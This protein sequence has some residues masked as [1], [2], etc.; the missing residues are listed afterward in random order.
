MVEI[1]R[2]ALAA[3]AVPFPVV[4]MSETAPPARVPME[5]GAVQPPTDAMPPPTMPAPIAVPLALASSVVLAAPLPPMDQRAICNICILEMSAGLDSAIREMMI[6][7]L[8]ES[9]L[10]H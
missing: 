5:E 10:R 3:E 4:E 9:N 1:V 7:D 8:C 2:A 6:R